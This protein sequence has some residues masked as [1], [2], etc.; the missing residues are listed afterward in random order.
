MASGRW[1][2]R[3]SERPVVALLLASVLAANATAQGACNKPVFLTFD[4]GHMGIA[5]LVAEKGLN[6]SHAG[7]PMP[8]LLGDKVPQG[9]VSEVFDPGA[10]T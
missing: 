9:M 3:N 8:Q 10:F 4:T 7:I 1:I 6:I 2:M 5:P